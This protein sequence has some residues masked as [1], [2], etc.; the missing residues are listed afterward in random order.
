MGYNQCDHI[1]LYLKELGDNFSFKS[2]PNIWLLFGL[3]L[4]MPLFK[5]AFTLMHSTQ[6]TSSFH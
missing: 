6:Y 5:V 4:E 2:G 1:G 3:F